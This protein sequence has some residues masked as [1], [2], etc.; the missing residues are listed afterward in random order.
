MGHSGIDYRQMMA[1]LTHLHQE[2]PPEFWI[3]YVPDTIDQDILIAQATKR[4][5]FDI[6][7]ERI[8][9]NYG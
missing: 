9:R 8:K 4:K 7:M 1:R 2:E 3:L 6:T 5:V